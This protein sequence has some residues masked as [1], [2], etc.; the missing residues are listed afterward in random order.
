M[1]RR[2][3]KADYERLIDYMRGKMPGI[4]ITSDIIVGF[5]G[6]REEDFEQTLNVIREV[7]YDNIFSFIFSPRSARRPQR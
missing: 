4:A 7:K 1:N 6:E 5:P 2:Y 3:S